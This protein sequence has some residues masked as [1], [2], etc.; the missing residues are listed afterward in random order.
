[1]TE[2]KKDKP[3]KQWQKKKRKSRNEGDTK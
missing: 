2:Q 1:M 3:H